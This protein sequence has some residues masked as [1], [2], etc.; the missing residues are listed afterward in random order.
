MDLN[1]YRF[2]HVWRLAAPPAA[3]YAALEDVP[4]YPLWW[5][6]IRAVR[7]FGPDDGEAV[8][9]ALLPYRLV[10]GLTVVRRDP[11][12]GGL[13]V[14]MRGDLVGWSRWTVGA[15]GTGARALFEE[16]ARPG[17]P[18]LR[19]LAVPLHPVF[20]ANHAVMMRRGHRGLA[21]HLA[22]RDPGGRAGGTPADRPA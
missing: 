18:L 10:I 1:H 17:R 13:E 19:R 12:A 7:R 22:R 21:A 9:R 2:R 14:A 6:E 15:D 5:P 3:V 8:V 4:G 16:D 20:R 11:V